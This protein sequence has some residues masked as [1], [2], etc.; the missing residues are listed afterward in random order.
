MLE[1]IVSGTEGHLS[2]FAHSQT[3]V[4]SYTV[5]RSVILTPAL[6]SLHQQHRCC[7][8]ETKGRDPLLSQGN[9]YLWDNTSVLSLLEQAVFRTGEVLTPSFSLFS[10]CQVMGGPGVEEGV[11]L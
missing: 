2:L 9:A 1:E 7:Q 4:A 3:L 6:L 10:F 5:T 11:P 8:R